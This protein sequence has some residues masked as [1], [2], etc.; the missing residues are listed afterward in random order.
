MMVLFAALVL[1][2]A[3]Y[4]QEP[5]MQLYDK[6]G[7]FF[8]SA[9]FCGCG[10][11]LNILPYMAVS[12]SCFIYHYMP[13]LMYA[14]ITAGL[15]IDKLFPRAWVPGIFKTLLVVFISCYLFFSPWIYAFPLTTEGH[16]RR[17]WL[18]R[19]D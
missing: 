17:R 9:I 11:A 6:F 14:Q 13:A 15:V 2:Y 16:A 8:C 5:S 18:P 1:I 12:R 10:Y 3:R 19:W 4:R 7:T